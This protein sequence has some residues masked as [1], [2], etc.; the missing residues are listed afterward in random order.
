MKMAS[1]PTTIASTPRPSANAARM[2]A[3]P[4]IWPAASGFRPMA[5][6]DRPA[7]MPVP[8]PG[9]MTPSAAS[10]APMCSI[11]TVPPT[12]VWVRPG[13][14]V[15]GLERRGRLAFDLGQRIFRDVALFL[16]V[17]FDGQ[18]DEH[19]RQD[20]EDEGLD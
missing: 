7:R 20:A 16:M 2:I 3:S 6:E 19:Q 4:R 10:P 17:A 11:R 15:A 9:P 5:L 12:P 14:S 13:G 18:D 1:R 8:M